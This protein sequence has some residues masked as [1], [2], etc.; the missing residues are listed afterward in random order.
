MVARDDRD[1]RKWPRRSARNERAAVQEEAIVHYSHVG[2]FL[3]VAI[4]RVDVP[5]IYDI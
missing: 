4:D 3:A 5:I 1:R 2:R